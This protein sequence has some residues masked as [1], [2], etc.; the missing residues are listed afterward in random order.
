[1]SGSFLWKRTTDPMHRLGVGIFFG[2]G[3]I[4]LQ[5]IT[6]WVFRQSPIYY[7]HHILL[8]ALASLYYLKHS[9]QRATATVDVAPR[10]TF[11]M[12]SS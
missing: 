9:Q 7:V 6:E 2:F 3:G 4:F 1:M 10:D 11:Q 5:S 8:G 12:A